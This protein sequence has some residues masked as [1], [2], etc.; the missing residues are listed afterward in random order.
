MGKEE[1]NVKEE[2]KKNERKTRINGRRRRRNGIERTWGRG[3]RKR[4]R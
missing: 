3:R 4:V 2:E 1:A